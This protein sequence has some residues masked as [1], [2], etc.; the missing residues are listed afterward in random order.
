MLFAFVCKCTEK[1]K[2]ENKRTSKKGELGDRKERKV[3]EK[4]TVM[5]QNGEFEKGASSA[6][7]ENKHTQHRM[8]LL[9]RLS[10]PRI[11]AG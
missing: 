2:K 7:T 9:L 3:E 10:E 8:G 5:R 6:S 4:K 11:L 1:C